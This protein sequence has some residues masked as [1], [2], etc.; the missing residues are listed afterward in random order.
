MHFC[1]TLITEFKPHIMAVESVFAALNMRTAL[2]L[3]E[4]RG[5]VLLA[6]EQLGVEVRSYS[7]REIKAMCGGLWACGQETDAGNGKGTTANERSAG[8]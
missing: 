3:A 4:M 8:A 6:G 2:R 5:V 1:A 7:P